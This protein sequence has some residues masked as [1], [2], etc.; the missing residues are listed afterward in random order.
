MSDKIIYGLFNDDQVLVRTARDFVD[1]NIRIRDVYSPFP[2]HGL[3]KILGVKWTRLAVCA[4]LFG[5]TGTALALLG[6][7]YFMIYDWPLN[8]GGKPNADLIQNLPSFIPVTFE[9]AVL[10]AGHGMAITFLFRN[11]TFP[12]VTAR[13]PHPKTTDDHFAMEI[14]M[15]DNSSMDENELR[16]LLGAA[17]AVEIWDNHEKTDKL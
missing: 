13:N 16:G 1:K 2:I 3:E 5:L 12:G 6:M 17:G 8:I 4:F 7:W 10:C 11:W 15:A 14:H 9:F